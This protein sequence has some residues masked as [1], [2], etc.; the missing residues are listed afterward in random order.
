[1]GCT[2]IRCMYIYVSELLGVELPGMRFCVKG[3]V[4]QASALSAIM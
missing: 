1:M 4:E 3:M 2:I